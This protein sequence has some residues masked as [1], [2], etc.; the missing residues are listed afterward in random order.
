[1]LVDQGKTGFYPKVRTKLGINAVDVTNWVIT[2]QNVKSL[3][4]K[5]EMVGHSVDFLASDL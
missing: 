2:E 4:M 1:M 5:I 3:L